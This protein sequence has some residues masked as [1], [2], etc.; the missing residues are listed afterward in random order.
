M[1]TRQKELQDK[2][3]EL[4]QYEEEQKNLMIMTQ[5]S[6][7]TK[8]QL[9]MYE[10][11][12]ISL[13]SFIEM[14]NNDDLEEIN[15]NNS[16]DYSNIINDYEDPV[17]DS[18]IEQE[19]SPSKYNN[20]L[21]KSDDIIPAQRQ[22]HVEEFK[23]TGSELQVPKKPFL[24]RGAG[25]SSRFN[26]APDR[27]SLKKLPPYKYSDRI[28][29]TLAKTK[30]PQFKDVEPTK[31]ERPKSLDNDKIDKPKSLDNDVNKITR[32]S[33]P[34]VKKNDI[35]RVP[36]IPESKDLVV[37]QANLKIPLAKP[38]EQPPNPIIER[39]LSKSSPEEIKETPKNPKLPKGVSWA[40]ILSC[41]NIA[42]C[43]VNLNQLVAPTENEHDETSLFQLLEERINNLNLDS[44]PSSLIKLLS[45]LQSDQSSNSEAI[46]EFLKPNDPIINENANTIN[47]K[48]QP[49]PS[50]VNKKLIIDESSSSESEEETVMPD[51]DIDHRVRFAENVEFVNDDANSTIL[52]SDLDTVELSQTSTPNER[53]K[54]QEFKRKMLG[55]STA[56]HQMEQQAA[57][58]KE[59][60]ELLMMKLQEIE[61][62]KSS[63]IKIRSELELDK[64]QL[65]NER[66]DIFERLKDEKI[67]MEMEIHDEKMK[68]E[69]QKQ[70]LDKMLRDAK[71]PTKKEREE[72]TKLKETIEEL[73]E[74]MKS[75]EVRHGS[76]QA[77]YRSQIKVLE[78]ENQ[79]LKLE[80]E[81]ERKDNKKLELENARLK[82]E[83]NSKMLQ[84]I[85]K[86]IAKLS[87]PE[88][89]TKK[90]E[91]KKT[92]VR[93]KSEP[94]SKPAPKKKPQI[95]QEILSSEESSTDDDENQGTDINLIR[96]RSSDPIRKTSTIQNRTSTSSSDILTE[97]KREI[98]NSD[99][100]KDI[101]YP[102][103]NLKKISA[104]GMMIRMLYYNKDI[105][106]TNINEGTVKYYYADTN[107]W[108]TTYVDGLEILEY[109]SGEVEHRY[110]D[111]TVEIHYT[112]GSIRITNKTWTNDIK[113][114]WRMPDGTNAKIYKN[115]TKVLSFPNGQR[116]IHT[117]NYKRREFPDGTVKIVYEDGS[118][119]TR[120][121]NGRIRVK[122]KD[123]NLVSDTISN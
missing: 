95:I 1:E 87:Q 110:K 3:N 91:I 10:I 27:F 13:S 26:M 78:K 93:R 64:I 104:D 100:S 107:T 58:L 61:K 20:E 75:K 37:P 53:L 42:D 19:K 121:S 36:E 31:K 98:V 44:S 39:I 14:Q 34:V 102:N 35:K 17:D 63:I 94:A 57:E 112:D 51:D 65:E 117:S 29:K 41:N 33:D 21:I 11:L 77:R 109:P 119:E 49:H 76:S 89:L 67:R 66:D 101:W 24:R 8:E 118:M 5:K 105:K 62:E 123:G 46:K 45:S 30:N 4:K 90:P 68:I 59:K 50:D 23:D 40:Q 113:E 60:T 79:T 2:L 85:N 74:E 16:D 25:L 22:F 122:D 83:T 56:N 70:K 7:L 88:V 18:D 108:H 47:L 72:V 81:A 69:Q 9:Q 84:E 106:E 15:D 55:T 116:E 12:G 43:S 32:K 54:F 96:T 6:L 111:N 52:S 48:L 73:K 92:E 82:R 103:G 28:K 71:N 99:G 86:N 114:E 115:D 97:M 80:L 120:Y 38:I